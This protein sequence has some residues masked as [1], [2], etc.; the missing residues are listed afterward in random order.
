M[1]IISLIL[2]LLSSY[3]LTS[4]VVKQENKSVLG[5]IY[6]ILI[7]F[8][9]IILGFELLS[10]L[11]AVNE[12]HFIFYNVIFMIISLRFYMQYGNGFYIPNLSDFRDKL[13]FALKKDKFLVVLSLCFL[14]FLIVQLIFALFLPVNFGDS[15]SY[16]FP[17][18]MS[19]LQQGNLN[20][21]VTPDSR[22]LIMPINFDLLYLW[23][24]VFTKKVAYM[25]IFSYI[26]YLITIVVLY[27]FVKELGFSV[28]KGLWCV[29][30]FSSFILVSIEMHTPVSDLTV[31]GLILTS[32]Y[33]Y[34]IGCKYNNKTSF[35]FSALAYALSVGIKT[36]SIIAL[37][38]LLIPYTAI[39]CLYGREL[40]KRNTIRYISFIILNFIIFSSY[41]YILNYIQFNNPVS[42]SEQFLLNSF[43]GGFES[44]LCSVIK[45][46][47]MLFDIS[48][49]SNIFNF[50]GIIA[51]L[52]NAALALIGCDINDYASKYF[53][54]KFEYS[55][56][57]TIE[58]CFL[59]AVGLFT[60]LPAL[61]IS[62]K[63]FFK[64]KLSKK[65]IILCSLAVFYI[66]SVLIFARTMVYTGFNARYLLTFAVVSSPILAYTY[67]PKKCFYKYISTFL[68]V[69]YLLSLDKH[70]PQ[71]INPISTTEEA[72]IYT[73]LSGKNPEHVAIMIDQGNVPLTEIEKLSLTG[74]KIDKI[75]PEVMEEQDLSG[76]DHIVVNRYDMTSTNIVR[77]KERINQ[78]KYYYSDCSYWDMDAEQIYYDNEEK[79]AMVLCDVPF[80][81][82]NKIGFYELNEIYFKNYVI[83]KRK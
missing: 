80:D 78:T 32:L 77:F 59:G 68:V 54:S 48:G 70:I 21:F 25:G 17:R 3:L 75:L 57:A 44:W 11:N 39:T 27:N 52:Q 49:I 74:V 43:R 7:A 56:P 71:D 38:T 8:A 34:L 36:T 64:N 13:L 24:M 35:Y 28:R 60:F 2:V 42:N 9:Q 53:N 81:Y 22:E 4:V 29:F 45:Y 73:Y 63:R 82:F 47:Y 76:Y 16:Y 26:G 33:L 18:A 62:F 61:I 46:F 55:N 15:L 66:F 1:I 5:G 65:R 20:H 6:F 10:L 41:N 67:L 23:V 50:S 72:Q 40:L 19:W 31:G 30:V 14:V 79:P 83:L 58:S 51:Y 37:P 12:L 69:I